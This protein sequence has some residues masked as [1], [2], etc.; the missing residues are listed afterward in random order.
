MKHFKKYYPAI[1]AALFTVNTG[2]AGEKD[3]SYHYLYENLPFEMPQVEK[4]VFPD[5]SAKLTEYGGIPDGVTLNTDA[6]AKAINALS[7]KGGGTLIVPSGI[8]HTGPIALKSNIRL[9]LERGALILFT[10][11]RDA[12]PVI[13]T[14]FEGQSTRKAQSPISGRNLENIAI[15]GEGAINGSGETWRPLKKAKVSDGHWQQVINSGG[16]LKD[17]GYWVPSESAEFMRPVMISFIECKNI[18]LQGV[19]F[20]N[21]P[22]WNIHPLM[23]ENLIIDGIFVRNPSYAQNGDGL[24][25][26]SCKNVIV[27]N[28]TLDVGDDAI[29]LKSGKDEQGRKRGKPTE[30]VIVDNCRVFKGHGGFVVGS[31]MSGG[32][33][34]ISVSNCQ[35]MG[36]DVGLRF[37]SARG[38]G[39]VVENI[40]INN[41]NMFNIVNEPL[42]FDLYYFT[43]KTDEIPVAD[44]TTPVFKDIYIK[45]IVSR[46]SNKAMFFNGLP[47]MNITN[48]NVEN[49]FITSKFG[50]ELSEAENIKLKNVT[51]APDEGAA[52]ILN[53]IKNAVFDHFSAPDSLKTIVKITGNRNSNIRL[54][55]NIDKKKIIL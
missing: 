28:T 42:L 50:A 30:N 23:C 55:G 2:Y 41:I 14:S 18:L 1:I 20:E 26:E 15:T 12:Y 49:A 7:E 27:V 32:V 47:E 13:E 38:R 22:A 51:V 45:D 44:E 16:V 37:K 9:H 3:Y 43:R 24:D 35:F 46:N 54:P 33:K 36:T 11:D 39:G 31:E 5:R 4:P 52:L 40:F 19:L 25:I 6:F 48:I 29:C 53:N 34:N 21:S 10:A 17:P 8:W